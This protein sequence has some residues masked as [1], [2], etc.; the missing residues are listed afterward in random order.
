[1]AQPLFYRLQVLDWATG[2]VHIDYDT[3]QGTVTVEHTA[4]VAAGELASDE[5]LHA[6]IERLAPNH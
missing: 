5:A 4:D 1:M 3:D 2:R 6:L